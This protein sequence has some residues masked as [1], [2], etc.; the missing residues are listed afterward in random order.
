[1]L[2]PL[3][4]HVRSWPSYVLQVEVGI[5]VSESETR[6]AMLLTAVNVASR[7]FLGGVR[8]LLHENGQLSV[9]WAKGYG[10]GRCRREGMAGRLSKH[11]TP[12]IRHW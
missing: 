2:S 1:M 6:Q 10:H 3:T 4:K 8:V 7:A 12:D 9:G 11:W 5:G